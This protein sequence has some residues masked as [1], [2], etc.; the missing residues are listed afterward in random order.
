M[1]TFDQHVQI[2]NHSYFEWSDAFEFNKYKRWDHLLQ[3]KGMKSNIYL[4]KKFIHCDRD[5]FET[6]SI[7]VIPWFWNLFSSLWNYNYRPT[8]KIVIQYLAKIFKYRSLPSCVVLIELFP[9]NCCPKLQRIQSTE[10]KLQKYQQIF[11]H[12]RDHL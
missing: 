2:T 5:C 9:H 7:H 4:F 8:K 11:V 6:K 1:F 3:V 10:K 12:F